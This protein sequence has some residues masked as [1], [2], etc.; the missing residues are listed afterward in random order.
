MAT[1]CKLQRDDQA[2][3]PTLRRWII[4]QSLESKVGHI[5]SA[6]CIV[7]IMTVLWSRI[8][9]QPATDHPDRDRF[10]LA[11]GHAALAVYGALRWLGRIDDAAFHS[12]CKEGSPYAAH[13]EYGIPGVEVATG[14][15]GQGLSVGCGLALALRRRASPARVYV[16][17]SDAECNEG[18]VWEAVMFAAHHRLDNLIVVVD[19]NGMQA[20]GATSKVLDLTPMAARWRAFGW[21]ALEVDGHDEAALYQALTA[22]I[23]PRSGPAVVVARTVLGKGVGYMENRLEW[24][25]KN[26]TPPLAAQALEQIGGC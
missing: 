4:E 6:L 9:R 1:T 21:H 12:Y 15:L 22:G 19:L 5:G 10:I 18:Q 11:K 13:P 14:S 26:L 7:D 8:L 23:A 24:H 20:M 16:L 25:Y 2:M 3:S 17:V